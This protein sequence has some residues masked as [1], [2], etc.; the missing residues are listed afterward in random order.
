MEFHKKVAFIILTKILFFSS[1]LNAQTTGGIK[2]KLIDS[3]KVET[4]PNASIIIQG[5]SKGVSS[6]ANGEFELSKLKP[7]KYN[8]VI[9]CTGYEADTIFNVDVAS[10][11]VNIGNVYLT[12]SYQLIGGGGKAVTRKTNSIK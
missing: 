7:G 5:T 3:A 4:I 8:I 12:A 6:N 11:V 9:S 2:G 10:T 1:L